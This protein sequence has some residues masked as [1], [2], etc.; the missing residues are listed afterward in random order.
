MNR[1]K[2][3]AK[4]RI[5]IPAP[6][7]RKYNIDKDTPLYIFDEGGCIVIKPVQNDPVAEGRGMLAS[8]GRVLRALRADRKRD[9]Q[10]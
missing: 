2:S 10:P 4:G 6:L 3:T 8:K 7:R 1:V 9:T 5:L